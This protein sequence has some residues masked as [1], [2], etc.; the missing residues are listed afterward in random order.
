MRLTTV[1]RISLRRHLSWYAFLL[2]VIPQLLRLPWLYTRRDARL[3]WPAWIRL[4][5][6]GLPLRCKA[7]YGHT[8]V[9]KRDVFGVRV[10]HPHVSVDDRSVVCQVAVSRNFTVSLDIRQPL[11]SHLRSHQAI[12][13]QYCIDRTTIHETLLYRDRGLSVALA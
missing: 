8:P 7:A 5:L 6:E 11:A 10:V 2:Q 13:F 9:F 12:L 3:H 1:N 4:C